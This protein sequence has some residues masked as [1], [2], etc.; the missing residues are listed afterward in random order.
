MRREVGH[1]GNPV[2][3]F[4]RWNLAEFLLYLSF[5]I[6]FA[7]PLL[8]GM[9]GGGGKQLVSFPFNLIF[10]VGVFA[11]F[12]F[13]RKLWKDKILVYGNRFIIGDTEIRLKDISRMY[14]DE[15]VQTRRDG[16]GHV[17]RSV[18]KYL[19][20]KEKQVKEPFRMEL[21]IFQNKTQLQTFVKHVYDSNH[22]I[23]IDEKVNRMRN[24]DY[25]HSKNAIYFMLFVIILVDFQIFSILKNFV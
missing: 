4:K 7:A 12:L 9:I 14:Y 10:I 19:V 11:P 3:V 21:S 13:M 24:G 2:Y 23:E 1:L 15:D 5:S 18:T 6:T 25:P 8:I 22:E 20:F 16:D 17:S